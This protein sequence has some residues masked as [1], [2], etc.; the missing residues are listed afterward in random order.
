MRGGGGVIATRRVEGE[1]DELDVATD[2][3]M[4]TANSSTQSADEEDTNE[5]EDSRVAEKRR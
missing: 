4:G 5:A 3:A 2:M 1:E